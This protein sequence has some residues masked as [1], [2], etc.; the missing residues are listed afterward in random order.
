MLHV[1]VGKGLLTCINKESHHRYQLWF[2]SASLRSNACRTRFPVQICRHHT[3]LSKQ[4][5][6]AG[7]GSLLI[8]HEIPVISTTIKSVC[9]SMCEMTQLSSETLR[10]TFLRPVSIQFLHVIT[11]AFFPQGNSVLGLLKNIRSLIS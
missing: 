10:M 1:V 5:G 4:A 9:V 6:D 8:L 11:Q 3:A 7:E 2:H